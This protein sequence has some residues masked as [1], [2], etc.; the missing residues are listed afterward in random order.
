MLR[1]FEQP[2]GGI[3]VYTTHVLPRLL[4]MG[5]RHQFV[6]MYQNPE[7]IGTYGDYSNVEEVA[8][9]FP[10]NVPW[11]QLAVPRIAERERLDL[12]FNPKLTI[13]MFCRSKKAFVLHGAEWFVIPE[14]FRWFDRWYFRQA[15][16]QYCRGADLLVTVSETSK[17]D[18]V[19]STGIDPD[20]VFAVHNGFDPDAFRVIR[21]NRYLSSVRKKYR[22]PDRFL[23]WAGQISPP[24]NVGRLLQAFASIKED[25]PHHLVLAGERRWGATRELELIE[26]L[27]LESRVHRPGWISHDELPAFYNLAEL[28]V[29]PSLYEGFG[30][31]LLESMACGCPI[32][33][34]ST[35]SPPEVVDGAAALVDPLDASDIARGIRSVLKDAKLRQAL[36]DRGRARAKDFSWDKCAGQTL[37][38]L[39]TLNAY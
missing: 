30:I 19:K 6:L 11:D 21:D 3:K 2:G 29:F 28:F 18:I 27:G 33:T 7:L 25:I 16:P 22:L 12:V 1:H 10:G 37:D 14:R 39:N 26:Q 24:K 35:G 32:V 4:S 23:L 17:R 31:P 9:T 20:K 38:V 15:A 13:P 36:V 5:S 8:D 34:A